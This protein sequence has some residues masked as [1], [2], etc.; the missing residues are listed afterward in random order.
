MKKGVRKDGQR[1]TVDH[2]GRLRFIAKGEGESRERSLK[3]MQEH[4]SGLA[5]AINHVCDHCSSRQRF[6]NLTAFPRHLGYSSVAEPNRQ[7]ATSPRAPMRA[8]RERINVA[9]TK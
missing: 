6:P 7:S 2:G 4:A 1:Q 3:E 9:C 5:W 8:R